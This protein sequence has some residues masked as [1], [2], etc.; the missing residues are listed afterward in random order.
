MGTAI[1]V[2]TAK[3]VGA[4][5]G[6]YGVGAAAGLAYGLAS[7]FLGTGLI[8][9]LAAA[10]VAGAVT[11]NDAI[12]TILGFVGIQ[13]LLGGGAQTQANQGPGVM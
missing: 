6:N 1:Q 10:A 13:A 5:M 2:P 9:S 12:P 7:G 4:A 8:G 3:G 11:K